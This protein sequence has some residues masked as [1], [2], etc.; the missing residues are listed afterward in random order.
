M[1]T[2]TSN[3]KK[4]GQPVITAATGNTETQKQP[5]ITAAQSNQSIIKL[6]NHVKQY[7]LN[8]TKKIPITVSITNNNI[9]NTGEKNKLNGA[10]KED[11]KE[12]TKEA[13]L[14][15]PYKDNFEENLGGVKEVSLL[16]E[17]GKGLGKTTLNAGIETG[18]GIVDFSEG[19]LDTGLQL[20]S[21]KYNPGMWIATGQTPWSKDQSKLND[22]QN[23]AKEIV[24]ADA[25]QSF[26][27]NQ[28]GYGKKLSNGKTIQETLNEN[29]LIKSDN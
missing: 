21:S 25:S 12:K 28:L 16:A 19:I 17:A 26:I 5:V 2:I 18:K 13:A 24:Q 29:S 15:S 27:D 3:K 22:Y 14:K 1:A 23:I 9:L 7:N 20:G 4:Y 6:P 10:L 11:I 8:G